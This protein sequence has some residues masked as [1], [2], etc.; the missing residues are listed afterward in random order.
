MDYCP[1]I[2]A[3]L[4][5]AE[6]ALHSPQELYDTA[7]LARDGRIEAF[8]AAYASRDADAMAEF[9]DAVVTGLARDNPGEDPAERHFRV[10]RTIDGYTSLVEASASLL[11]R[12]PGLSGRRFVLFDDYGEERDLDGGRER[13]WTACLACVGGTGPSLSDAEI[14]GFEVVDFALHHADGVSV[15]NH[16]RAPGQDRAFADALFWGLLGGKRGFWVD[17]EASVLSLGASAAYLDRYTAEGG[18]LRLPL[19]PASVI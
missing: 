15:A 4:L 13:Y 17:A 5:E 18:R 6:R 19:A 14:T 10:L 2:A 12:A 3:A 1:E 9:A 7:A 8:K 16:W 11:E